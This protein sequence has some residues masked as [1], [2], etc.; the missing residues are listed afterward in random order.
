MKRLPEHPTQK[1]DRSQTLGFT[2]QGRSMQGLAGDSVAS[3]LHA[4]GVKILGRSLKYHRPRGLYSLDGESAN[5]MVAV[6]GECNVQAEVTPLGEGMQVSPQ[7]VSGSPDS[8][9]WGFLDS[10]DGF[11]PAGFYYRR[12]HKP[13]FIWPLALKQIRQR[14]GTGRVDPGKS[15]DRHRFSELYLNAEVCVLGGGPAGMSAALAAAEQG[16]RVVLFEGRPWLGGFYDW[17]TREYAPGKPLYQ[18]GQELAR[19]VA[20]RDNIRVFTRTKITNLCGD[21]LITAFQAGGP[22]DSFLQRYIQIRPHSVVVATGCQERPL[23]FEHNERPG[24]MQAGY[25]LRLARTYALLPGQKAVFSVGDDLGLEAAVDLAAA[26]LEV[27]AVADARSQGHDKEMVE[28]LSA[29]GIPFLPGWAASQAQGKKQVSGA[30]LGSLSGNETKDFS[31]DLI[32]ASAGLAPLSGPLSTA[33]AKFAFDSYTCFFLPT[34]MPPRVHA[35]GRLLGYGHAGALEASGRLAG[36]KAASDCGADAALNQA[37]SELASLPGPQAGCS[38]TTGPGIG[39]GRKSFI[40]FDEDG[41]YKTAQQCVDQGF[42]VPELAKRFGVFGLGPGQGGI[43]G[44]NLPLVLAQMRGQSPEGLLPTTVRSPLTPILMGTLAGPGHDIFKR[45]PMHKEQEEAG[46]LFRRV[47]VWQRARYFSRD[48][49]SSQEIEAVRQRAGIIDVSTLGKF[50]LHG[51]DALKALQRVYISDMS[52]IPEGKLK[53]SAMLNYDGC[54]LDDGVVA[55]VGENDYYF[56]ASTGRAGGTI[57]W[58]RYYTRSEGWDFH[59]VNLTD[60]LAAI[61]LAGPRSREILAKLTDANLSNEAFPYMGFREITLDGEVPVKALRVGFVGEL[62]YELHFPASYGP[63]VW[64]ML[65]K[66]GEEFGIVSFGLEAQFVLRLEKGHIIIGQE[67]E[68]RVN[69]L[70]LGL[71]FLWDRQDKA[72]Q[73]VGAPALGFCEGQT[74]RYKLVG[75]QMSQ[76]SQT[77]GDGA[78]IYKGDSIQGFVCTCRHSQTLGRTIGMALVKQHLAKEGGALNIYQ[79]DSNQPQKYQATVVPTP[80]YDPQGQRLRS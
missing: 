28:A 41:T 30:I 3:A 59:L 6:D 18:R 27:L 12:F 23:V 66:A 56:T 4:N 14:A 49:S 60:A 11:M 15:W 24:V 37:E 62:A 8:D 35:A 73:K 48:L 38:V 40:C 45:T 25:A 47:G 44:A 9:F 69:L 79:N 19:E 39:M 57:E 70:D 33:Q 34:E 51:P 55:Q 31:C 74:D 2:W 7:N 53:Y 76:G 17:R 50:R 65:L 43:P 63:A 29:K 77:P 54:I 32:V 64:Q 21:N 72:S 52:R 42:D 75:F 80:F 58:F 46:A 13:A 67:T 68:Q 26:G 61:N 16:L 36:L 71:G 5:S 10:F 78:V 1:I 22:E 20:A